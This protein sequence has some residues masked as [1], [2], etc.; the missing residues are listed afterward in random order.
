M[1]LPPP[2]FSVPIDRRA[3]PQAAVHL[4]ADAAQRAALARRFGISGIERLEAQVTL[5]DDGAAVD[6]TGTLDAR[7]VQQCVVAAEDFA[8]DIAAPIRLRFVPEA[9]FLAAARAEPDESDAADE[10]IGYALD[11]ED[12]DLI[13]FAGGQF[14]LGEAVAQTL[15]LALDPY[16]E[17]PDA[18]RVR[19]ELGLD[20]PVATGPFA[21][22]QR[23]KDEG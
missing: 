23:L 14:D 2:E 20:T 19:T 22:L 3:L 16:P 12:C 15:A 4:S 8:S 1:S 6:A 13:A 5:R 11:A 9:D 10:P 18:D 17:G 21:A 7:I